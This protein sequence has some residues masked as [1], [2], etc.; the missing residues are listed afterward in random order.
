[1]SHKSEN[2][3]MKPTDYVRL[4]ND[5]QFKKIYLK[6]TLWWC[7]FL[8][9]A[10]TLILF[11]GLVGLIYIFNVNMLVSFYTIP[12]L[13]VFVFGTIWLKAVKKHIQKT[14]LEAEG[15]YL[16]CA[17]AILNQTEKFIQV[18]FE[19]GEKRH[20]E[21]YIQGVANNLQ[22]GNLDP[23]ESLK[24]CVEITDKLSDKNFIVKTFYR[25]EAQKQNANIENK[26]TFPV[27][28]INNKYVFIIKNKFILSNKM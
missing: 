5:K 2:K 10:P 16:V 13:V 11:L 17:S 12:F 7:N 14:A 15:S 6:K 23:K 24:K 25:K 9:I 18:I 1:M 22:S 20:N 3:I 19:T 4:E 26:N 21:Y 28:Y 27:L 8:F